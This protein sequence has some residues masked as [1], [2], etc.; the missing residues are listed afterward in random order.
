MINLCKTYRTREGNRVRALTPERQKR[1]VILHGEV[2]DTATSQLVIVGQVHMLDDLSDQVTWC[3]RV[4]DE[5]GRD[6]TGKPE[7]D[8]VEY[9]E[10]KVDQPQLF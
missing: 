5:D 4:W 7:C 10:P 2:R 9:V 8:L 6:L 3:R 1:R